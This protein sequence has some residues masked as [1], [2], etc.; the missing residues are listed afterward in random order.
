[1]E[2]LHWF[3]SAYLY[4]YFYKSWVENIEIY[5][6][7]ILMKIRIAEISIPDTYVH[8]SNTP[9]TW[10]ATMIFVWYSTEK[11]CHQQLLVTDANNF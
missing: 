2:V 6:Y 10:Q 4:S 3:S 11:L 5:W 9:V 8:S 1:M 7:L